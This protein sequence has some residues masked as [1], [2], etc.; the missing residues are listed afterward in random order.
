MNEQELLEQQL[1]ELDAV[2]A[3]YSPL[4]PSQRE[5]LDAWIEQALNGEQDLDG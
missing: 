5:V 4:L 2:D 1:A 3:A